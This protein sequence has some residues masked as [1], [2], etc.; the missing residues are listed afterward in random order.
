MDSIAMPLALLLPRVPTI[1]VLIAGMAFAVVWWRRHPTRSLL[2][3]AAMS[4]LLILAVAWPFVLQAFIHTGG[5]RMTT[6]LLAALGLAEGV[7]DATAIGLLL[8]AVFVRSTPV[9]RAQPRGGAR[10]VDRPSTSG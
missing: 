3:L 4:L 6:R 1:L 2:V 8:T 7:L 9:D 5:W 10:S